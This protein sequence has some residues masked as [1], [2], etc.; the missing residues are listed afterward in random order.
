VRHEQPAAGAEGVEMFTT[1]M[2]QLPISQDS[3]NN[4]G[5]RLMDR[6][7]Q[8]EQQQAFDRE[9]RE[10]QQKIGR[11]QRMLFLTRYADQQDKNPVDLLQLLDQRAEARWT[12]VNES[13][14]VRID[15]AQQETETLAVVLTQYSRKRAGELKILLSRRLRYLGGSTTTRLIGF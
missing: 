14:T 8:G 9:Q 11:E 7:R 3:L 12:Q 6:M 2:Q 10:Q 4:L 15:T 13:L 5:E 1:P